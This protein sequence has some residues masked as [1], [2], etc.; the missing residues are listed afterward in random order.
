L[1][2]VQMPV[3]ELREL[4]TA[5]DLVKRVL[6]VLVLVPQVPLRFVNLVS[7]TYIPSLFSWP[8]ETSGPLS[9][10]TNQSTQFLPS[11]RICL[12]SILFPRVSQKAESPD[13]A[14]LATN[15]NRVVFGNMN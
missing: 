4:G 5:L 9:S 12:I 3:L 10:G 1:L 8:L 2:V 6:V 7:L 14:G 15:L 11:Q 13:I